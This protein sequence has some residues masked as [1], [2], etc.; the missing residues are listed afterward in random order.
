MGVENPSAFN[1]D[2]VR[3]YGRITVARALGS[4][5]GNTRNEHIRHTV[6]ESTEF[7]R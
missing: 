7:Q 3:S 4:A 1:Q 6:S 5:L 2:N